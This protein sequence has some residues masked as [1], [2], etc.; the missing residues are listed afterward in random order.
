VTKL[1]VVDRDGP[2]PE[3]DTTEHGVALVLGDQ[4]VGLSWGKVVVRV[5]CTGTVDASCEAKVELDALVLR[6][7]QEPRS[8]V[9]EREGCRFLGEVGDTLA[10]RAQGCVV[11]LGEDEVEGCVHDGFLEARVGGD[12]LR[13]S[14]EEDGLLDALQVVDEVRVEVPPGVR[15]DV[16]IETVNCGIAKGTG[17]ASIC[18]LLGSGTERTPQPLAKVLSNLFAGQ[19]VVCI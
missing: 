3:H 6:V 5:G 8:P 16:E 18:P 14:G 19:V 10:S 9:I 4:I 7:L 13:S 1:L 12:T 2:L 17:L 15:L 11:E